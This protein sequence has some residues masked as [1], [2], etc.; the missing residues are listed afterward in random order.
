[1]ELKGNIDE[2]EMN[3]E[4]LQKLNEDLIKKNKISKKIR[5][6]IYFFL[7][8]NKKK[9]RTRKFTLYFMSFMYIYN[10]FNK[11]L[12]FIFYIASFIKS[13]EIT[14]DNKIEIDS[15]YIIINFFKILY[16]K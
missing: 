15:K 7:F 13:S 14:K 4:Q 11:F 6:G 12:Y 9:Y 5:P 8:L 10:I 1:M 2:S 16:I 3:D